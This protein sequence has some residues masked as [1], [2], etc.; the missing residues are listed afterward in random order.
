MRRLT[1]LAS[2]AAFAVAAPPALADSV[3]LHSQGSDPRGLN[4]DVTS[5]TATIFSRATEKSVLVTVTSGA[6]EIT[7]AYHSPDALK[8]GASPA[9][10]D[11]L[12]VTGTPG[13]PGCA[14]PTA[15]LTLD[16]VVAEE[17]G[18]SL[19]VPVLRFSFDQT[20][21]GATDGLHGEVVVAHRITEQAVDGAR[22]ALV[23]V[24]DGVTF[25]Y[26]D[27]QGRFLRLAYD[28]FPEGFGGNLPDQ[29]RFLSPPKTDSFLG[30]MDAGRVAYQLVTNPGHASNASNIHLVDTTTGAEVPLPGLNTRLWESEPDISGQRLVYTRE[31]SNRLLD[32]FLYGLTTHRRTR[33]ARSTRRAEVAAEGIAGDYVV[34]DTCVK[35]RCSIT[36][37]QIS[38]HR[39]VTLKPAPGKTLYAPAVLR[40]GTVYTLESR[41]GCGNH[42]VIDRWK[43]GSHRR[44]VH[45]FPQGVDAD[46]T[47]IDTF[48]GT[49]YLY[50]QHEDC[51][52]Q[53][54]YAARYPVAIPS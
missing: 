37:Y 36:R 23:P 49:T 51:R 45:A 54:F 26:N 33:I 46:A 53:N 43:P 9:D 3:S 30:G 19:Q 38:T 8:V 1:V 5:A 17:D 15:T 42:V 13:L 47:D 40:D 27:Q 21:Q 32:V 2:L 48:A 6:R 12:Q 29:F 52:A 20:C 28:A 39:K 44:L 10:G 11:V 22:G 31:E 4:V 7:I 34:W 14:A 50:Y 18:P 41:K 24:A 16:A 25:A 35:W